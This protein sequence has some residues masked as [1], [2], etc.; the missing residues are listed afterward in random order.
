MAA[1]RRQ[2]RLH[3][4]QRRAQLVA[5]VGGEA[6][7]RRQRALAVGRRAPEPREHRVEARA[8]ASAARPGRRRR[9]RGGRGPRRSAIARRSTVRSRR[10]GRSTRSAASHT[11]RARR[12]STIAAEADQRDARR[13][14]SCALAPAAPGCVDDL[15]AREPAE[16]RVAQRRDV[17]AVAPR[18]RD[19]K[20]CRPRGS[21]RA[22]GRRRARVE[23]DAPAERRRSELPRRRQHGVEALVV[24]RAARRST[25]ATAVARDSSAVRSRRSS[26]AARSERS[27]SCEA[28]A[29]AASQHDRQDERDAE[30]QAT[31]KA[32]HRRSGSQDEADA[33]HRVQD[34][35]L[36][37]GLE[38][39]AQVADEDVG[40]VRAR[41]ERVAPDLLVQPAAVER[42]RPGGA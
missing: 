34:A 5:G 20:V 33:A 21:A 42:P 23:Q 26:S 36:A 37:V 18:R 40:D 4:G 14:S 7:R 30:R 25:A 24:R 29:P 11:P 6:P 41:I 2:R 19:S 27:T 17:G 8:P 22:R 39:A 16:A 32:A 12:T 10:S 1:Q 28:T 9:A 13:S 38:L 35:R 3:A 15:Q 31:T